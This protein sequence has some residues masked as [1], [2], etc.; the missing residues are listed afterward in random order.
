MF[1]KYLP[2]FKASSMDLMAFKFNIL[3]WLIISALQVVCV[4]CLW[5][6]VYQSSIN[7]VDSVINGFAFKEMLMY[8]VMVNIFGFTV[9]DGTT[10]FIINEEIK[11]GTIAM[12]FIKPTSYRLRFVF[13]NLGAVSTLFLMFGVPCFTAAY[14]IF[15]F[16]GFL[17]VESW[18][19]LLIHILLFL[20]SALLASMINDVFS[21]IFGVLCFYTSA[22]WGLNQLKQ[23][24][25][26]FLSGTL[27]P[28]SF[29]PNV[30]QNI[31]KYSPFAGLAQ[32]PV[33]IML[34]KVDVFESLSMIGLSF[35][36]LVALEVFAHFLFAHASKKIT[37]HGG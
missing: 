29:M 19:M 10:L 4:V 12:S 16:I 32:N 6:G 28:L 22:G 8:I 34:M 1:K 14:L 17:I 15:Y 2:F 27:I 25:M 33:L 5:I 37:V 11:D 7:G 30:M 23:V 13:S 31:L 26:R 20:I 35:V 18:Y 3:I 9:M 21:Y 24:I 36:W